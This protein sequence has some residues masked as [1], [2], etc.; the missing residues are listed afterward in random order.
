MGAD[1]YGFISSNYELIKKSVKRDLRGNRKLE[2][3][4]DVFHDTLLKCME[5]YSDIK[6]NN[7]EEF[8]SYIIV[9]F[10]TNLKRD[11]LYAVNSKRYDGEIE[12]FESE[13]KNISYEKTNIDIDN[14]INQINVEFGEDS[15]NKFVDWLIN[16][17]T[18]KDINE[19]YNCNNSRY[20]IDKIK[21]Y[22]KE[23]YNINDFR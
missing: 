20:I 7:D 11:K 1:A 22:I 17:L 14:L 18:I 19:K 5:K 4:E 21:E 15:K 13:F 8:I 6:F 3:D 23:N 16:Q 9:S 2:F 12:D 10:K